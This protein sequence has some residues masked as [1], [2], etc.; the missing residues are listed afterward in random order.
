MDKKENEVLKKFTES[1]VTS[2]DLVILKRILMLGVTVTRKR[3]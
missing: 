2:L 1:K 3:N